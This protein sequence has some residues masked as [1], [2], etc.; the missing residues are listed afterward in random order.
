[1]YVLA[2]GQIITCIFIYS[3]M[4]FIIISAIST[5]HKK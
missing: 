1:V 4:N 3:K 5:R 2:F